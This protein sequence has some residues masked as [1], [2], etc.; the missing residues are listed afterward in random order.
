MKKAITLLTALLVLTALV[1]SVA[2]AEFVPSSEQTVV[3]EVK[4]AVDGNGNP[5]EV[6]ASSLYT[7]TEEVK[8]RLEQV[9]NELKE[10]K[11]TELV[12][13]E[14]IAAIV[15]EEVNVEELV[16]KDVFDVSAT[17]NVDGSIT[18]TL[19]TDLKKDTK[20]V[21]LHS[22][23]EGKWEVIPSENVKLEADGSLS[24]TSDNGLSPFAI[25]IEAPAQEVPATTAPATTAPAT[26]APAT[27][28]PATEAPATTA[29]AT[30]APQAEKS[31]STP[32]IIGGV[33]IAV[34]VVAA[35]VV[36][37]KKKK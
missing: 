11:V 21:V 22:Y 34:I 20:F 6:K 19:K 35:A 32:L 37:G 3:P 8:E 29:P 18:F 12:P 28:A 10:K 4:G 31:S 2:A 5:V 13:V 17:E 25:L 33:V 15:G 30:E 7:A 9:T 16:V 36:L 26:E 23:E 27:T 14:E 24:I 1:F